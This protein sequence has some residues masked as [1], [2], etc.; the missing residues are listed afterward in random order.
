MK[1]SSLIIGVVVVVAII[2]IIVLV[3]GRSNDTATVSPTASTSVQAS[4]S[5]SATPKVGASTTP[6]STGGAATVSYQEALQKYGD[7]RIQFGPN[8]QATPN[9][10]VVKSGTSIM[11]DNRANE[12]RT[13][14]LDTVKHPMV[15]YGFRI[16]TITGAPR[17]ITI[18]CGGGQNVGQIIVER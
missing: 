4:T 16:T 7:R 2:A 11:L 15:A 6:K 12:A 8:C 3:G 1:N 14:S 18:D 9:N 5:V 13:V 10:M 17:T